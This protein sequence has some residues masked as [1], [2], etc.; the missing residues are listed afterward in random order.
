[1][2]FISNSRRNCT[3]GSL[4]YRIYIYLYIFFFKLKSLIPELEI[5]EII[6]AQKN[7]A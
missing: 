6:A 1:M 3:F 4:L 5:F 2:T 7:R